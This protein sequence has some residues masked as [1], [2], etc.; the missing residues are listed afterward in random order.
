MK[1]RLSV[2]GITMLCF[3]SIG[4]DVMDSS[5]Q[6]P[7]RFKD[8]AQHWAEQTIQTAVEKK[9]VDGYEDG[10]FKPDAFISRAE[11]IK[12][13]VL[14]TGEKVNHADGDGWFQPYVDRLKAL[15]IIPAEFPE[16]YNE[17]LQRYE[18]SILS[19]RSVDKTLK[20]SLVDSTKM[21]LIHGVSRTDLDVYGT[22]TRAQAI[23]V[24]ER[25]LSARKGEKLPID[26]YAASA[27]EIA[28]TGS[29]VGTMLGLK[30][31]EVGTEW[32]YGTGVTV[33]L[34]QLIIAD[35]SDPDDPYMSLIDMNSFDKSLD[36]SKNVVVLANFTVTVGD[37]G[38][39][40]D[41][42]LI[43][44]QLL[45]LIDQT[46][47]LL[48]SEQQLKRWIRFNSPQVQ[49]GF[50]AYTCYIE[51]ARWGFNFDILGKSV[52]MANN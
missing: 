12:M 3:A 32:P 26:K 25:I 8:T 22:S 19:V 20:G 4:Y 47:Q 48:L 46:D 36:I 31:K 50:V 41:R 33:K 35:P 40:S 14:A 10:T 28:A 51:H 52:F 39:N 18:M 17:P 2:L 6:S 11:F 27:A 44:Q 21:G 45:T 38:V 42:D 1:R 24:I 5:A 16:R 30:A 15:E 9:Y 43:P 34:N 13:V 49:T 29:N 23:T 7:I 37:A